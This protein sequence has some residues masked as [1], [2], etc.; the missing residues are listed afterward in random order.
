VVTGASLAVAAVGAA[1]ADDGPQPD[2]PSSWREMVR[3]AGV[4][5]P[6]SVSTLDPSLPERRNALVRAARRLTAESGPEVGAM[7][8]P[9]LATEIAAAIAEDIG[10]EIERRTGPTET[11]DE[12]VDALLDAVLDASEPWSDG[13]ALANVAVEGVGDFDRW[14]ALLAP[15][16]SAVERAIVEGQERGVVRDDVEPRATALVLR[17]A[18][19]RTAKVAIRFRR[20]DYR[21]TTAALVRGALAPDGLDLPTK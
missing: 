11:I 1:V 4:E 10:L 16:L 6:A 2:A 18:L 15:W 13:L 7:L 3:R 17:D 20:R 21:E 9:A 19:D 5:P 14:S 8:D 12:L